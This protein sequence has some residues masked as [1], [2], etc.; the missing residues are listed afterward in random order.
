MR[1]RRMYSD[2]G[3]PAS[4]ENIRRR[5]YSVVPSPWSDIGHIDVVVEMIFD[6]SHKS[7]E[8]SDHGASLRI[9]ACAVRSARTRQFLFDP[10]ARRSVQ[11]MPQ[12]SLG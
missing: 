9:P 3:I 8:F 11:Q 6:D 7:V 1:R 2:S 5:W 10:V 12:V 4:D